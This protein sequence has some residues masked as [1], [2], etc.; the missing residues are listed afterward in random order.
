M[1]CV[2]DRHEYVVVDDSVLIDL[3]EFYC[4]YDAN[5]MTYQKVLLLNNED[6]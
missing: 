4:Q 3:K 2:K 1:S 6:E 5:I